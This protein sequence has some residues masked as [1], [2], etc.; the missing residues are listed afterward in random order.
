MEQK[1]VDITQYL[2]ERLQLLSE[3][4]EIDLRQVA[5]NLHDLAARG[6]QQQ[7]Q[8]IAELE[9]QLAGNTTD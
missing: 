7:A 1:Q 8:K 2:Q 6:L 9:A 5:I 4:K 3:G